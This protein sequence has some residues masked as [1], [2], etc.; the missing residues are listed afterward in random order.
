MVVLLLVLRI[1]VLATVRRIPPRRTP[2]IRIKTEMSHP[3]LI[4]AR[5]S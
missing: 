5:Q 2:K 3:V 4:V 1:A